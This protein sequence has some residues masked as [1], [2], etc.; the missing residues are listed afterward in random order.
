MEIQLP[1]I[2]AVWKNMMMSLED[3]LKDGEKNVSQ[4]CRGRGE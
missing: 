1:D 2:E 3:N 4:S